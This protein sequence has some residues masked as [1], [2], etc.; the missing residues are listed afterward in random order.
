MSVGAKKVVSGFSWMALIVYGNRVLG[1]VTTLILAKFLAPKDF[2]LIA[3][4]SMI[5]EI[6]NLFK[7]IGLSE[8]LIYQKGDIKKASNTAFMMVV[9]LNLV[10]FGLASII[11]PFAADFYDNPM[12]M[13]VIILISSNLVWNSIR[14]V[15]YT[16]IRKNIDFKNLVAPD[17]IPVAIAS[18]VSIV[19][20]LNGYGVWSLV[21][22]SILVSFLGMALI[23]K[24]TPFRPSFSFD[25]EMAKELFRYGKF[26][27]GTTIFLVSLYNID[28]LFVSKFV[29]IAALG[30]YELAMRIANLPVSEFSHI[31]GKVMFPVFSK[32]NEQAGAMKNAFLK[33]LHYSSMVSIPMAVGISTYG[34]DLIM[35][36]YGEKWAPMIPPLQI[37]A[38]YAMMRSIS[39]IIYDSFK[40]SGNPHVMQRFV[41]F[42]LTSVG[43]LGIPAL[44][45][46]GLNAICILILVT[47][48]LAFIFESFT[49]VKIIEVTV[50]TL[51][52]VFIPS[53]L[54]AFII[55]PGI[56]FGLSV[57]IDFSQIW[58]IIVGV[59]TTIFVYF[60]T[61]FVL[62]KST[63]T[64][65]RAIIF[66]KN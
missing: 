8:A 14:A 4:A 34:P 1:F 40:A 46:F 50:F 63:V 28:K 59:V 13:P 36:V 35:N 54:K 38:F 10:L 23:W 29:G 61:I 30:F 55:I 12:V 19:M 25:K 27:V 60:G 44:H 21:V 53:L 16:L 58:H 7:D 3:I 20:A 57:L 26:I 43:I 6:L 24:F 47:Y 33:T 62:D 64:E 45:F 5:I 11:A 52:K 15:P 2:G 41:L 51:W 31:V 32:M 22:R 39:S 65:I 9:G 42:K 48:I 56:Y 17:I 37:L 66:S 49:L 18:V